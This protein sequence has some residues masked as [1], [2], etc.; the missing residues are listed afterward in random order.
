MYYRANDNQIMAR[1]ASFVDRIPNRSRLVHP[2]ADCCNAANHAF[3]PE[4][5]ADHRMG[6]GMSVA[7]LHYTPR[8]RFR[9]ETSLMLWT[10]LVILLVLWLVGLLSNVG[11]SLIHLLL[12]IAVVVLVINLVTG[13]RAV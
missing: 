8:R 6:A 7:P 9:K 2:K 1:A 5:G 4:T 11:G 12:V 3:T 13:R 10:I